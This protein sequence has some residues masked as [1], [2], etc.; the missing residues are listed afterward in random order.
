MK[1]MF[2]AHGIPY[3]L[4]KPVVMVNIWVM[5]L[6]VLSYLMNLLIMNGHAYLVLEK[7]NIIFFISI[8]L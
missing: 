7:I 1:S 3:G 5:P 6:L 2:L 8:R 4:E